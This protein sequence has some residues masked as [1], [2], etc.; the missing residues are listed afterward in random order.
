MAKISFDKYYTSPN[1]ARFCI[2]KTY[3]ILGKENITEIVEPSAGCGTFSNQIENCK[4]YDLYPQSENITKQD[5]LTL[6]LGGYKKG[7]LFIGNPPYGGQS[8]KLIKQFYDKCVNDGDYIAWIL[9]IAYYDNYNRFNKFEIVYQCAIETN[10][11][12]VKI[13]SAFIIYKRNENI[14]EFSSKC[15]LKSVKF[16]RHDRRNNKTK[17]KLT[18][19]YDYSFCRFGNILKEYK[20]YENS[21]VF[22]VIIDEKYRNE[23]ILFLKWLYYYNKETNILTQFCISVENFDLQRLNKLIKIAIPEIE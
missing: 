2:E 23:V 16:I 1:T 7:R 18:T 13:K 21:N 4:A 9:P 3:E 20:V 12:N 8:G 14:S 22:G 17:H 11:S 19:N 15:E 10:Y 5:F 6:D